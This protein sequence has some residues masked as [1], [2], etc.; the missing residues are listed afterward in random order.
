MRTM[1][2]ALA[3]FLSV[4]APVK[5]EVFQFVDAESNSYLVYWAVWRSQTF[6]GYTDRYGRLRIDK[7]TGALSITLK[8][9]GKSDKSTNIT[10]TTADEVK[11]ITVQ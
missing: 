5:A 4:A 9:R 6:F 11:L 7:P 8:S 3:L 1:T 10:V 2:L